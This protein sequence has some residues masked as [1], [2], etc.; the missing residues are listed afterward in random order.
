MTQSKKSYLKSSGTHTVERYDRDSG[1]LIESFTSRV[2]YLAN[3]R[4][5]FYLMY[6][7]MVLVLKDSSDVKI[8]LFA[9]L[10][11][12]YSKGQEFSMG[13]T[14]KDIMAKEC[15]CKPRSFDLAFTSLVKDGII[16]KI[17]YSLYKMN[18]RYIF[19]GS[20]SDRNNALKAT[21]GIGLKN[22]LKL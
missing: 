9:S 8:K 11:E 20:S 6:S 3:T 18:P 12:R 13:K 2:T 7:S 21:I 17:G 15:K 4:E 16:V 1:E 5:E 19:Q 10:L 22:G 14:L